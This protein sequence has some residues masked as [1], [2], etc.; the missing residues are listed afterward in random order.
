MKQVSSDVLSTLVVKGMQE[1]KG[2]DVTLIDM[3][4]LSNAVAD[5]FVV[6]SGS[7]D[8]HTSSLADSVEV[9]VKKESKEMPMAREGKNNG[10]WVLIDYGNVVVHVF[11]KESR[12]FYSLEALWGDAKITKFEDVE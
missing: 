2:L 1:K 6:C 3:R 8:T 10:E 5:F 9:E 11:Q 7:S 12:E 4:N